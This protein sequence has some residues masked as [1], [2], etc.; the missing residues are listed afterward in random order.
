MFNDIDV[1]FTIKN[2]NILKQ[3]RGTRGKKELGI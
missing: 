3:P 2:K 1:K